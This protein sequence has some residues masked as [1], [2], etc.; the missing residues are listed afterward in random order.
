MLN[1]NQLA[2]EI[3]TTSISG[4]R[5]NLS[6]LRGKKILVKF[7]RFSGCPVAQCQIS[8]Y[9]TRQQELNTKGIET[10]VFLHSSRE[11]IIPR[12]REVP[13]LHI[14]PDN[15]KKYYHLFDSRFLLSKLFS[16][17]SW[18][19]TFSSIFKGYFPLFNRFSASISGIPSDFI[20]NEQGV[21][22]DLHYGKHFGDS[23]SVSDVLNKF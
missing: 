8:E 2:P 14:I 22:I 10:F 12:Y 17:A 4:K 13:G 1:K 7:H 20:I 23:W 5:V 6:E 16:L 18:G 19:A 9:I 3:A 21:I 11:K 15:E